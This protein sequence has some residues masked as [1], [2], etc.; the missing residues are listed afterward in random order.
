MNI[1]NILFFIKA[2]VK[3]L[4]IGL[5]PIFVDESWFK[6]KN[7]HFY[8]WRKS[9]EEIYNFMEDIKKINLLIGVSKDKVINYKIIKEETNSDNFSQF[10]SELINAMTEQEK[11]NSVLIM[12]NCTSHLSPQLFKF[13][14]DKKLKIILNVPYKSIFNMDE[15]VFRL[16]KNITYKKLNKN[17]S[18]L[19]KD[20]IL[21]IEGEIVIKSLSNLYIETLIIYK[22]YI[23][24]N[25]FKNLNN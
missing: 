6:T 14:D 25:L 20:L 5:N 24:S 22:N 18:E 21:I 2:L 7:N 11:N 4:K 16:I 10:I 23:N 9:N 15:N 8:T 12:D 1:L 19:K 13:Y 3:A 17:I